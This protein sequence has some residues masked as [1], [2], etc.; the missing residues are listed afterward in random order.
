ML[1]YTV[2]FKKFK[3]QMNRSKN[4]KEIKKCCFIIFLGQNISIVT[5]IKLS[6]FSA[7]LPKKLNIQ[8]Y[9][10]I[11]IKSRMSLSSNVYFY[12]L[13]CNTILKLIFNN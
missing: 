4:K 5:I 1:K 12:R 10:T 7:F 8:I 9:S 3:L 13:K 6:H 2:L 11:K